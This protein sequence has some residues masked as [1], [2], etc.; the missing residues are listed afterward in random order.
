MLNR[1]WH[2][3]MA[4]TKCA[5]HSNN[6]HYKLTT[7]SV[8]KPNKYAFH[9]RLTQKYTQKKRMRKKASEFI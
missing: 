2:C 7:Y 5:L 6:T 3:E 8:A 1:C 4:F 9:Q